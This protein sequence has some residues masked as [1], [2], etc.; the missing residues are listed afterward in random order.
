MGN[1]VISNVNSDEYKKYFWSPSVFWQK[2]DNKLRIEVFLYDE[3][4]MNL[5]PKFFFLTQKGILINNLIKEFPNV[6]EK[7][8]NLFI[9][10]LV[11][12]RILTSELLTPQEIFFPQNRLY[13]T[14]YGDELLF[15]VNALNDFKKNQLNRT[16]SFG[17]DRKIQLN[18]NYQYPEIISGRRSYRSFD[19][20]NKISFNA[21]S[22]LLSI[23]K[24]SKNRDEIRYYYASAGGLYPI[25]VFIYVKGNRVENINQGI[26][27]YN[28]TENC[29][30]LVNEILVISEDAHFFLNR[31]IFKSSAFSIYLIYNVDVT[32]PKYKSDAYFYACLD[33]GIMVATLTQAAELVNIG[34]CSIGEMNFKKIRKYFKLS[35]KQ[36]Y[37][38]SV[39]GGLKP[40]S[41]SN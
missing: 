10:D 40:K 17:I 39:E 29:I 14:E 4:A 31:D 15:D 21:F 38:H 3:F 22:N 20:E 8:L 30:Q 41:T 5:F 36:I 2:V 37:I 19:K 28:P 34:L 9:Q 26:Y 24:Q 27:Y 7:K 23:F 33:T 6:D 32:M 35:N 11:K 13:E 1:H 25:D 18:N 16:F 12:K